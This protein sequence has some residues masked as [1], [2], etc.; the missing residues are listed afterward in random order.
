L[1]T[2]AA[3]HR[4]DVGKYFGISLPIWV[5][6]FLAAGLAIGWVFPKNRLAGAAYISG[7]WFPKGVVT[8]AGP[9]IFV[10]LAAA[11]AKLVLLHGRRAQR[12]FGLIVA[13]YLALGI[14]SLAFVTVWIPFLTKLPFVASDVGVLGPG[15]WL[16]QVASTFVLFVTAQPLIQAL[17][18]G[19]VNCPRTRTSARSG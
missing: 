10:L 13:L 12:L 11:T 14:A 8:F 1:A 17:I 5:L 16:G 15:V 2:D 9:L 4:P 6:V 7:S 18:G 3:K 19:K